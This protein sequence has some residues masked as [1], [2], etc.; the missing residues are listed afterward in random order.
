MPS[1]LPS[2]TKQLYSTFQNITPYG[3]CIRP[4]SAQNPPKPSASR[5]DAF[6][7]LFRAMSTTSMSQLLVAAA[8]NTPF[9]A[10][11]VPR[12]VGTPENDFGRRLRLPSRDI[13]VSGCD[14]AARS[15]PAGTQDLSSAS[16]LS[17]LAAA[18][19]FFR[20]PYDRSRYAG[21]VARGL[22]AALIAVREGARGYGCVVYCSTGQWGIGAQTGRCK[23]NK[24]RRSRPEE[25]N[26]R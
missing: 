25:R 21:N 8:F 15:S 4:S 22:V 6:P 23:K 2:W 11:G 13:L 20:H 9:S 1:I 7:Y 19:M 17:Q 5:L 12:R 10:F 24:I 26:D 16:W 18:R 3:I 14:V